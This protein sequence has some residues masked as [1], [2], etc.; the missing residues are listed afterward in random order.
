MP[1]QTAD[2]ISDPREF[3]A[4]SA[5]TAADWCLGL[6]T[7]VFS[8]I[9]SRSL[10]LVELFGARRANLRAAFGDPPIDVLRFAKQYGTPAI[11]DFLRMSLPGR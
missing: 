11:V 6:P 9:F 8:A 4:F 5:T 7:P 2:V 10:K 3:W 1:R